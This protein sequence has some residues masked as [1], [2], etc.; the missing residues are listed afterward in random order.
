MPRGSGGIVATAQ[1][2]G[3][4]DVMHRVERVAEGNASH[5][6]PSH[7][8]DLP[9]WL[10]D[11]PPLLITPQHHQRMY[12][13][14]RFPVTGPV[15]GSGT[16]WLQFRDAIKADLSR[17]SIDPTFDA[18]AQVLTERM[19]DT[20]P[21]PDLQVDA[22]M[23]A[24]LAAQAQTTT[25]LHA[26]FIHWLVDRHGLETTLALFVQAQQVQV[27]VVSDSRLTHPISIHPRV[28]VPLGNVVRGPLTSMGD[29]LRQH[30]SVADDA[31]W[32]ACAAYIQ[33]QLPHVPLCRQ[34]AL[35]LLLPDVPALSDALL[36]AAGGIEALPPLAHWL[37]TTARD[38]QAIAVAIELHKQ[39]HPKF[40][41]DARFV[42]TVLIERGVDA[43]PALAWGAIVNEAGDAL[44]HIGLPEAVEALARGAA[45]TF[46]SPHA[47][48]HL[49]VAVRR[50]PLAALAGLAR[51]V[52]DG[53]KGAVLHTPTVVKL[54]RAL[55]AEAAQVDA[56]IEP[57]AL[58]VIERQRALLG[59]APVLA[60]IDEIPGVL[61]A[62][63]WRQPRAEPSVV[64]LKLPVLPVPPVERWAPGQREATVQLNSEQARRL[65]HRRQHPVDAAEGIGFPRNHDALTPFNALAAQA[66]GAGDTAQ[67]IALWQQMRGVGGVSSY[68]WYSHDVDGLDAL[69]AEMA[70]A[71]CNAVEAEVVMHCLPRM[72]A[73]H[74]MQ[75]FPALLA[76]VNA[77]PADYL[78]DALHIGAVDLAPAAARAFAKLKTGREPGRQW[79]LA[80]PEHAAAG[81]LPAAFGKPGAARDCAQ[82]ALSLLVSEGHA[83]IVYAAAERHGSAPL[84][85]AVQSLIENG[86]L[87][88]YPARLSPLP[89]FWAPRSWRRPLLANGKALGDDAL[90]ALGEML[91]F[92]SADE[93]YA[94]L[95]QVMDACQR[96]S[97]ADFSWDLFLA[98]L[99]QGAPNKEAWALTAL[100]VLGNDDTARRLTAYLRVWPTESAYAR[101]VAGLDVLAA[102]GTDVAL[103]QIHGIAQKVKSKGLQDKAREKIAQIAA[104]RALTSEELEDRLAPDLELDEHGTLRLDFGPR[105]FKVGFDEALRPYVRE[106][107]DTGAGPRLGDLPK[108]KKSDDAALSKASVERFKALKKD[109]R[110]IASQQLLRLELAMCARR[111]WTLPQFRSF[112]VEHPLLRH[113]VQ[114][115]VWGVYVVDHGQTSAGQLHVCFR[116]AED[117]SYTDANDH[118]FTPP[119]GDRIRIGLPHAVELPAAD[120]SAFRA[121]LADYELVQPFAQLDRQTYR[122]QDG[123]H[124]LQALERWRG[125]KVPTGRVLGLVDKGWRRGATG[126][127][128]YISW[129]TKPLADGAVIALQLEPGIMV[130]MVSEYPEQELGT[131]QYQMP[132]RSGAGSTVSALDAIAVSE[133]IRD[134]EAL[135]A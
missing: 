65:Q 15:T 86:P 2:M 91:T 11:G 131:V 18:V 19:G 104:A 29:A 135:R 43:L 72:L 34:P 48:L 114:R 30:L 90:A 64:A 14:R 33:Q 128:G 69:P 13:S 127:G 7:S 75:V 82:A 53:G 51:V 125:S 132:A 83:G 52:A 97:L 42:A 55:G 31:G 103:M 4:R 23:L 124:G 105:A 119:D 3:N 101:A 108:P 41:D 61:A 93:V 106:L 10:R 76:R 22:L 116:V 66:I 24:I 98:W 118:A 102:I 94:G 78:P 87:Q 20:P 27:D 49:A 40:W 38:P 16:T 85:Q 130:A 96:D 111:R 129:F 70:V 36:L 100:G 113:L 17:A 46:Y 45:V 57:A 58:A 62:P 74:G 107:L 5:P 50:W 81:L 28:S 80:F 77:K 110:T 133:L 122:L 25:A 1:A 120:A 37:L 123:E 63:P 117:G 35:A 26:D 39:T 121:L 115:L 88:R 44:A 95:G 54:L 47:P 126:D 112:L 9:P 71:F 32:Q 8:D 6:S 89:D 60:A 73:L 67:L 56:W 21:A 59:P 92:P 12:A 79:L 68:Y 109:V 134:L 84:L 99:E